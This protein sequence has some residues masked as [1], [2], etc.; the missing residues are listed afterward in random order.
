MET[1]SGNARRHSAAAEIDG[2]P[3]FRT[4]DFTV[5]TSL[6]AGSKQTLPVKDFS[7]TKVDLPSSTP[8]IL[9]STG[10]QQRRTCLTML[11]GSYLKITAPSPTFHLIPNTISLI[12]SSLFFYDDK[13][14]LMISASGKTNWCTLKT[15]DIRLGWKQQK[16][17]LFPENFTQ[18]TS[19]LR[20]SH[21]EDNYIWIFGGISGTQTQ[22]LADIWRGRLEISLIQ[23]E[24]AHG[25]LQLL[26]R[27]R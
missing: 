18:R 24:Q 6:N 8:N 2:Q 4:D 5:L 9:S 16:I 1:S 20:L 13:P 14:Y 19:T 21:D 3:N 12:G 26:K 10:G 23:T 22:P 17:K 7:V 25:L 15:S 27:Q 11:S